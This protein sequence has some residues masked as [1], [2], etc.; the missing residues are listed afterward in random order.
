MDALLSGAND[1]NRLIF[2]AKIAIPF[3]LV[4]LVTGDNFVCS[5]P[6]ANAFDWHIEFLTQSDIAHPYV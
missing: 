1:T 2:E 5:V 3:V 4:N 6:I